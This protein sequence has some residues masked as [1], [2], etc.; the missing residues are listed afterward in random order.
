ML[1]GLA[2]TAIE[3]EPETRVTQTG[4]LGSTSEAL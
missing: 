3:E 4:T 1:E 2:L